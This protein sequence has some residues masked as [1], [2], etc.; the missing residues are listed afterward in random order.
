[1]KGGK[2]DFF[3]VGVGVGA[4]LSDAARPSSNTDFSQKILVV[5]FQFA[6]AILNKA[7]SI[8]AMLKAVRR[9]ILAKSFFV[10]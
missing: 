2:N 4:A 1:L 5:I 7:S 9:K 10:R 3:G 6:G 8:R